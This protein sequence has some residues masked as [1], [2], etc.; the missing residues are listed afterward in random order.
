MEH[1]RGE[2]GNWERDQDVCVKG[3]VEEQ[4]GMSQRST[5]RKDRVPVKLHTHKYRFKVIIMYFKTIIIHRIARSS[6]CMV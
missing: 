1:G 2:V 3:A 5:C 4:G 6:N